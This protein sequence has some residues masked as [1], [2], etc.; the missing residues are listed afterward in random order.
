MCGQWGFFELNTM[1]PV[2]AHNLLQTIELLTNAATV[3]AE[4][5]IDGLEAT[6]NGPRM[7]EEGLSIGTPLAAVIGYDA[8]AEL[9]NDAFR[10]GRTIRA[11]ATERGILPEAELTRLLDARR[12][13]GE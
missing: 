9:A 4:K 7:V 2:A 5:C 12:M 13:T 8:A 3:L 6:E 11:L 1:W 10:T